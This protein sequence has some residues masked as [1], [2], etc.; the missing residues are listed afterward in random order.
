MSSLI[1]QEATNVRRH[2]M[3]RLLPLFVAALL[4]FLPLLHDSFPSLASSLASVED[5]L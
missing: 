2:S 5:G 4:L 3:D 1:P